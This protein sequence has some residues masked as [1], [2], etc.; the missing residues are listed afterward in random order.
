MYFGTS[1]GLILGLRPQR[2]AARAA[3]RSRSSASTP[4][5]TTTRRSSSTT[6]AS[7]TSPASTTGRSPAPARSASSRSS[8]RATRPT[9][10]CGR[11]TTRP[12]VKGGIYGTPGI[13]GDTVYVGTN[14]GRLHRRRPGHRCGAVG[15]PPA[16]AGVGQPGDRRRHAAHR[17]LPGLLPR[18]RRVEPGAAAARAVD[19]RARRLHRGHPRGVGRPH[20]HRH[21]RP[22]TSTSSATPSLAG[23]DVTTSRRSRRGRPPPSPTRRASGSPVLDIGV[24]SVTMPGGSAGGPHRGGPMVRTARKTLAVVASSRSWCSSPR[25][26]RPRR[27]HRQP[28]EAGRLRPRVQPVR[29]RRRLQ[30]V[31]LDGQHVAVVGSHRPEGHVPLLLRRH[32]LHPRARE[33]RQQH[34]PLHPGSTTWDRYVRI[35][36]LGY[37][38]AWMI[39]TEYSSKGITVDIVSH[40]MGGLI[41]RY[42]LAQI[43]ATTP[44]SRRTSTSRTRSRSARPTP[45]PAGPNWCW[46]TQCSQMRPGLVVRELARR[47]TARTRRADGGT[48]WTADRL[49]RRRGRLG[50]VGGVDERRPQGAVPRQRRRGPQRLLQGHHRQP[51]RRRAATATTAAPGRPGYDAPWPVRWT[52][53]ALLYGTW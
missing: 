28:A 15:A 36:H 34:P 32:E 21:P 48:D 27:A 30:H 10:S 37:R 17:R 52:D 5:V 8:T 14:G 45:A 16:P 7:S 4:A 38:L 1:A 40:S 50:G 53:Y 6:R 39:Y 22:A 44:T 11:S 18:L 19:D 20:L 29:R 2:G 23:P 33:L 26:P 12:S 41:T 47:R 42:A 35:E 25:P 49:L 24:T 13:Y 51:D 43:G 3:T 46:T 9:R 31:E